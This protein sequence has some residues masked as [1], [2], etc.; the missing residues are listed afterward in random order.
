MAKKVA[1]IRARAQSGMARCPATQSSEAHNVQAIPARQATIIKRV[2]SRT[3]AINKKTIPNRRFAEIVRT[4][5][6]KRVCAH[7]KSRIAANTD[8]TPIALNMSPQPRA[9]R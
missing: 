3:K 4:F 2:S 7:P 5:G 1:F 6:E 9:F 8:P